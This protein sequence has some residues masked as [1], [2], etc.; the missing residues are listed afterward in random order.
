MPEHEVGGTDFYF[1]AI[2]L[3]KI[4]NLS[5]DCLLIY[6]KQKYVCEYIYTRTYIIINYITLYVV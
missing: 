2:Y 4:P 5:N 3:M 6:P 1:S